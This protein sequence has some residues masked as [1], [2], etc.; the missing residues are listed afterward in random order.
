MLQR[1]MDTEIVKMPLDHCAD[2]N[3]ATTD[4]GVTV[5]VSRSL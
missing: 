1:S 5:L 3:T 4:K 2:V